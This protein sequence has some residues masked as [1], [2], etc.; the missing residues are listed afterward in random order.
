MSYASKIWADSLS[1]DGNRLTTFE[2]TFPRFVLAEFNTHRM[3]SR[4]SASSR[5]IP[6]EKLIERVKKDPFMPETFNQRVKGMGVGEAL[7]DKDMKTAQMIWR[8]ASD[9]AVAAAERLLRLNVDKS[10]ANRL[11]EP[12]LW[13]TAIVS[14]TEWDNFFAL[15]DHPAAQP[16]IQIIA[17]MMR[18]QM[19]SSEPFQVQYGEWHL[20][21]LSS[22]EYS[23]AL[24]E[25]AQTHYWEDWKNI[26]ASRCARVSFD[27]H[28][29][30]EPRENT[31]A[32]ADKL[33]RSV[34]AH[35][36]PAEHVARPFTEVEYAIM[37]SR[38]SE[39]ERRARN[40]GEEPV[41]LDEMEFVGNFRGWVQY[42]KEIPNE[43][44]ADLMI[45][46]TA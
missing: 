6:T 35:L 18:E 16:E 29:D 4:N 42:R 45:A 33:F 44:R 1:P 11:L 31:L 17:H 41:G 40:V 46:A 25:C 7:D 3:L 15:R 9:D 14:A 32:R 5:A 27:K 2:V 43:A 24:C 8:F 21:L 37:R 22:E 34:P 20:P 13:H 23:E 39:E 38:Q 36:S 19:E 30:E 26:S 12:F 28:L 10:R